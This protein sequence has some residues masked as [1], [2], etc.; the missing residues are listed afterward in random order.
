MT[1]SSNIFH[2]YMTDTPAAKELTG[3]FL[4]I[5]RQQRHLGARVIISTQEPTIS[6][7]LIDL[8]SVTIIHRFTSPEWYQIMEKH[9]IIDSKYDK[10]TSSNERDHGLSRISCLR[11][12]EALVFAPSAYLLDER[13]L[14]IDVRQKTFKLMV[15]KRI[16][17]DG[18][19][20][21]VCV[22]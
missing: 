19:Q 14:P 5:I 4:N 11:T 18:G 1:H 3:T 16:T 7:S 20:T 8:C 2:Q 22:R 6:P 13:S 15:R 12:G 10:S 9:I 17:W 21:I